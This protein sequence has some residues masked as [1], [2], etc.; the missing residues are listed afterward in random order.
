MSF[1]NT[2]I[3]QYANINHRAGASVA[4]FNHYV[5]F[6]RLTTAE[7]ESFCLKEHK[8]VHLFICSQQKTLLDLYLIALFY[9]NIPYS[10]LKNNLKT[11]NSHFKI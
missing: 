8:S 1:P 4:E 9:I 7:N 3:I 2:E 10:G 6:L 5:Y 11:S